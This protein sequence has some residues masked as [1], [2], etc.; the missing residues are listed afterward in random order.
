MTPRFRAPFL[1][2]AGGVAAALVGVATATRIARAQ[3][4]VDAAESA[5]AALESQAREVL[6]LRTKRARLELRERP[7]Q[8]VIAQVSA[9]LVEAG[10]PASALR[11]LER[12]GDVPVA[13]GGSTRL[14]RQSLRLSL[15]PMGLEPFGAFLAAFRRAQPA[16]VPAR[17]DLAHAKGTAR[18]DAFLPRIVLSALYV[19]EARE[20]SR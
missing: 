11:E 7:K 8:D 20:P 3:A 16:W 6:E 9:A 12:E 5:R 2:L 4:A 1:L 15:E 13:D 10:L 17:V 18:A 14:R 19:G